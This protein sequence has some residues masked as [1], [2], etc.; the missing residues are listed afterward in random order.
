MEARDSA[1]HRGVAGDT[2]GEKRVERTAGGE[3][4]ADRSVALGGVEAAR[5]CTSSAGSGAAARNSG[6]GVWARNEARTRANSNS[7]DIEG[8]SHVI[9]T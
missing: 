3:G 2:E 1:E 8:A 6:F 9:T 5:P 7:L 4:G